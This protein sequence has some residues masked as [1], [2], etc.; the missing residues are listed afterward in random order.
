M[1]DADEIDP[2]ALI[3]ESY[4]ID[5]ITAGECRS[6]FL[7][8]ALG[9]PDGEAALAQITQLVTRHEQAHPDHPMTKVLKG[10]LA[11]PTRTG[12]RGGARARRRET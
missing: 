3:A 7:D 10:A 4:R 1:K 11:V 2:R 8:W 6:I 5:G 9:A 12:R